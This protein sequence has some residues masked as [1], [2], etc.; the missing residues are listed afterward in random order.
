MKT[1]S[2]PETFGRKFKVLDYVQITG[3]STLEG[4]H[5]NLARVAGDDFPEADAVIFLS[6][7][8]ANSLGS[9]KY[10]AV[11]QAIKWLD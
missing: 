6:H 5:S 1:I 2:I 11:G 10:S 4:L 7:S 9:D 8:A 3:C